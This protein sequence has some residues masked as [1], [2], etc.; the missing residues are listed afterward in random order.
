MSLELLAAGSLL[1]MALGGIVGDAASEGAKRLWQMIRNRLVQNQSVI[2][3]EIVELEE[4][5]TPENLKPLEAFLQVEMHKDRAFAEA[6]SK[7]GQ[8]IANA[9]SGDTIEMKE[10]EAKDNAVVIGKAEA[11]TQNFG[12]TH[13]HPKK[14]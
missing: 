14:N 11:Q 10:F 8:E 13:L 9:N 3:G 5:P 2:E 6:I 7:L 1:D 12:G 4:N